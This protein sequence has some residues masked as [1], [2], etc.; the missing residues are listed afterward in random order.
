MFV[1]V[2]VPCYR[3]A[4]TLPSLIDRLAAALPAAAIGYEVVL[5]VDGSPDDTWEVAAE[6]ARDHPEVRAIR[7]ARNY[8]QHNATIAGVRAAVHDVIVTMDDDLQ[9]PPEEI[10][11]LLAALTDEVDLVY[12]HPR[13][14]E[15]GILR[16]LSSQLFKLGLSGPLGA[17]DARS[18]SAF[19]AFRAFLRSGLD[20]VTGPFVCIDVVLSW[21]T[22]RVQD[23]EVHMDQRSEGRS[24]YTL[25]T[26]LRQAVNVV[27]AYS[28]T[29]LRIV[30]YLGLLAGGFGACLL[31]LVLW[32]YFAG[33]TSVAGF[34][35]I[36]S[37][38]ALFS[39]AQMLG[40]GVLGEYLGRLHSGGMGRPTYVVRT[41][42]GAAGASTGQVRIPEVVS[43]RSQEG[44]MA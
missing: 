23:V 20:D 21:C 30:S 33:H 4:R 32:S 38:I 14:E 27:V 13:E 16:N 6:L 9:H 2:V 15:H 26:L 25:R 7:L 11:R 5:V 35:S 19:R 24:G 43:Q 41:E 10:P 3:S 36:A 39:S 22:R 1:S 37:M 18:L 40:I 17:R 29:P 34:T 8:G 42:V 31:G 44:W 12:G 28:S